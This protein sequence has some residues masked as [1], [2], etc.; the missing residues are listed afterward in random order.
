MVVALLGVV[1]V[2]VLRKRE[3]GVHLGGV[4]AAIGDGCVQAGVRDPAIDLLTP[5]AGERRLAVPGLGGWGE[6]YV[7]YAWRMDFALAWRP[8]HLVQSGGAGPSGVTMIAREG[9]V[10]P[11]W[12]L[13]L[14]GVLLAG[15]AQGYL[16]ALRRSRA[17]CCGAC[18]YDLRGVPVV[19]G[20][21][22]CPECGGRATVAQS[23][24]IA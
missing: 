5:Y 3:F 9:V 22:Q 4:Y 6:V 17:Q 12:P 23:G 19:Q 11:V 18:G 14:G 2:T 10:V 1:M 7:R 8:F 15:Y 24:Q 21:R 13:A 20:S 16:V